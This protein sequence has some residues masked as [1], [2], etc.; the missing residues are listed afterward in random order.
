VFIGVHPWFGLFGLQGNSAVEIIRKNN[1]FFSG[2]HVGQAG[3][4]SIHYTALLYRS[5]TQR[6]DNRGHH[7]MPPDLMRGGKKRVQSGPV[8]SALLLNSC[9]KKQE[10]FRVKKLLYQHVI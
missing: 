1:V 7:G 8:L 9:H 2:N 5:L 6:R 4:S 3:E 10:N